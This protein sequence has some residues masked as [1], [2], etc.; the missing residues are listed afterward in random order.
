MPFFLTC[1][2]NIRYEVECV[3]IPSRRDPSCVHLLSSQ[4]SETIRS[5]ECCG[6]EVAKHQKL[7]FLS[8]FCLKSGV[9]LVGFSWFNCGY[10]YYSPVWEQASEDASM[11]A[12]VTRGGQRSS[13]LRSARR[14]DPS[15]SCFLTAHLDFCLRR[16]SLTHSGETGVCVSGVCNSHSWV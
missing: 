13:W 16:A 10:R 9:C 8:H 12:Q 4:Q 11:S 3:F 1:A 14:N 5:Q 2:R 15:S 7:P 6:V